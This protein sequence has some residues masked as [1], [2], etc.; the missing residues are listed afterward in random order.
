MVTDQWWRD[1]R[2]TSR[3]KQFS[4]SE[5]A[6]EGIFAKIRKSKIEFSNELLTKYMAK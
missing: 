1:E 4:R 2:H 5:I 3:P 6:P